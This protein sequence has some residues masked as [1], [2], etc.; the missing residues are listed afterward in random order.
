MVSTGFANFRIHRN[1][2][3]DEKT[4]SIILSVI[5]IT[6]KYVPGKFMKYKTYGNRTTDIFKQDFSSTMSSKYYVIY[7]QMNAVGTNTL[8]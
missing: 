3:I 6:N 4:R 7:I 8:F 1:L 5:Y 2:S